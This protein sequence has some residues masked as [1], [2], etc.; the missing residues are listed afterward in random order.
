[1]KNRPI[2]PAAFQRALLGWYR[3]NARPLPW[4]E[5]PSLYKTVVSEFMLQQTQVAAVLPHFRRWIATWPDFKS[6]AAAGE[7]QV[8][9][10]WEGLGYYR[11]ARNLHRLARELQGRATP[12]RSPQQW[13]ELPGVGP[14]TAAAIS[15]IAFG[16][17]AA[18]VDGN[19]VRVLARLTADP[20]TFPDGSAAAKAFAPLAGE[21]LCR[22]APGD[23][24][25]AMME[26]GATLCVRSAPRCGQCPVRRFC[27]AADGPDAAA[28]PRLVAKRIEQRAVVRVWCERRGRLLLHLAPAA[29]GRLAGHHEL[30]T[31]AQAGLDDAAAA[32]GS[33]LLRRKRGITRFRITESIHACRAPGRPMPDLVWIPLP[34]LEAVV[35]SGPH[36]RWIREVLAAQGS[37]PRSD[38]TGL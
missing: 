22:E 24:N 35:L 27:A 30:P 4:R 8:L 11:R 13:R 31:A 23:H 18:C 25:Q 28:Y 32:K 36:R 6:L 37:S 26:L 15:S 2:D 9:K 34:R 14:Y 3:E 7:Q 29:S 17:P 16:A 33:L 21:L 19:V 1:M 38:S 5:N 10:G 12:P 20:R